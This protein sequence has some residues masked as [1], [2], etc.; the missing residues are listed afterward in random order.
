MVEG[1]AELAR[2]A[3]AIATVNPATGETL[4]TFDALSDDELDVRL[5]LAAEAFRSYR[6][7]SFAERAGWLV[8][9]D[10]PPVARQ[11]DRGRHVGDP[12]KHPRRAG[13]RAAG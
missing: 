6:L 9:Q 7:T 1:A 10:V 2:M 8:A 13:A 3:T 12:A 5:A 11:L 4:K